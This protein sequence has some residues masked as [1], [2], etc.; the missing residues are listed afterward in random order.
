MTAAIQARGGRDLTVRF[1]GGTPNE[2]TLYWVQRCA[3]RC[4]HPIPLTVVL[5]SKPGSDGMHE[6]RLEQLGKLLVQERDPDQLLAVRD[7]FDRLATEASGAV[8]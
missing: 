1:V 6:V 5:H 2:E 8:S 4:G 7:A 3:E